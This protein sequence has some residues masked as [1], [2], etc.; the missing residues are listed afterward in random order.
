MTDYVSVWEVAYQYLWLVSLL[1]FVVM[2]FLLEAM[3]RER[4]GFV[5][6]DRYVSRD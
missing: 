6:P 1:I 5:E 2:G 4:S 3:F